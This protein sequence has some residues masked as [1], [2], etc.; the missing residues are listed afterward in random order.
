MYVYILSSFFALHFQSVEDRDE[1][2]FI[3]NI[4]K[5]IAL[6]SAKFELLWA[7]D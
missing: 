6:C 7:K 3:H 4:N 1:C 2:I 5:L